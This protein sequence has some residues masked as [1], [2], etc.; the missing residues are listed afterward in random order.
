MED[1]GPQLE[2]LKGSMDSLISQVNSKIS[3]YNMFHNLIFQVLELGAPSTWQLLSLDSD[4][5]GESETTIIHEMIHAWGFQHEHSRPD[6]A[7][8]LT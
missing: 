7:Q 3:L 4:C 1:V 8:F 2:L 5:E 6:R